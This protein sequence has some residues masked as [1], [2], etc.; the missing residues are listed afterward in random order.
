MALILLVDF[1]KRKRKVNSVRANDV[2]NEKLGISLEKT[3]DFFLNSTQVLYKKF[4]KWNFIIFVFTYLKLLH[5]L[6]N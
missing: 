3:S 6:I 2:D 5:N 1:S 4:L